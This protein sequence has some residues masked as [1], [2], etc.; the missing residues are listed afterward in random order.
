MSGHDDEFTRLDRLIVGSGDDS[1]GDRAEEEPW[2]RARAR[3]LVK[4]A[5]RF[6]GSIA[7]WGSTDIDSITVAAS[8]RRNRHRRRRPG[9]NRRRR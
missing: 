2:V 9:G 7:K 3:E 1:G 8:L 5:N 6:D 4:S